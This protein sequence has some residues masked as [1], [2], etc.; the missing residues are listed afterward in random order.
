MGDKNPSLDDCDN[1][2]N[3]VLTQHHVQNLL[4]FLAFFCL[5]KENLL[6]GKTGSN[7]RCNHEIFDF[8]VHS[9]QVEGKTLAELM[10]SEKMGCLQAALHNKIAKGIAGEERLVQNAE[11]SER[12][13]RHT[14]ES[15]RDTGGWSQKGFDF[16]TKQVKKDHADEK[17]TTEN[18]KHTS[19]EDR[20][21]FFQFGND[22]NK[23]LV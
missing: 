13:C 20:P 6:M 1:G 8:G 23:V 4:L 9:K 10:P 2:D 17:K 18:R 14:T 19:E 21:D 3:H 16:H 22:G 11:S 7:T 15:S 12:W 5:E